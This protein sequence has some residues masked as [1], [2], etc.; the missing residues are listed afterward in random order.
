MPSLST[1]HGGGHP[2][3]SLERPRSNTS[4]G[5]EAYFVN[6]Q[7]SNRSEGGGR[8]HAR[9]SLNPSGLSQYKVRLAHW[10]AD[11][12]FTTAC[13]HGSIPH[14]CSPVVA[15]DIYLDLDLSSIPF[16]LS[17]QSR[18]PS[19]YSFS[20]NHDTHRHKTSALQL[21]SLFLVLVSRLALSDSRLLR[22]SGNHLL[23]HTLIPTRDDKLP[24]SLNHVQLGML[25]SS[26]SSCFRKPHPPCVALEMRHSRPG[27][28][29]VYSNRG[30]A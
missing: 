3:Y 26:A 1:C 14:S 5:T 18:S 16:P 9:T 29:R 27:S 8:A 11:P 30:L 19:P 17:T 6:K 28:S 4:I 15:L 20:C 21:E 12:T 10:S 2:T 23:G 25:H 24:L 22:R 13:T 7:T